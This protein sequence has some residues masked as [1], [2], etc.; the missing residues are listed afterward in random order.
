MGKTFEEW[1]IIQKKI[2][3]EFIKKFNLKKGQKV[4]VL[5][6]GKGDEVF[7]ARDYIGETGNIVAIDINEDKIYKA[8]KKS[9]LKGYK[10]ISFLVRDAS[11]YYSDLGQ[12]DRICCLFSIHYFNDLPKILSLW[13]KYL[14]KNGIIGI[15][16]YITSN[17]NNIINHINALPSKYINMKSE[18]EFSYNYNEINNYDEKDNSWEIINVINL[19]YDLCFDS[20]YDYWMTIKNNTYF[21]NVKNEILEKFNDLSE[22]VLDYIKLINNPIVVEK[23]IVRIIFIKIL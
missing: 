18:K 10:N 16:N 7:I 8:R 11:V 22:D 4:L 9:K 13:R 19:N 23:I 12:F 14:N 20:A 17:D 2:K 15:A 5:C 6:C 3:I 1:N 21:T